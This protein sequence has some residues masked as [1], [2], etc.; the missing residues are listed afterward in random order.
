MIAILRRRGLGNGSTIGIKKYLEENHGRV[1]DIV[2]SD[3]IPDTEYAAVLRWGCTSDFRHAP[4]CI[5]TPEMI[6]AANDKIS[7]R[8]AMIEHEVTVPKTFFTKEEVNIFPVIGRPRFHAQGRKIV[9]SNNFDELN[10]DNTSEYWSEIVDKDREYRIYTFMGRILMVAEKVPT[11]VGRE[12]LAWNHFGG[13][14]VFNNVKWSEW[15]IEACKLGLKA[16]EAIGIDFSGV[17]VMTKGNKTYILEINSAH[18]LSSEYRKKTFAKAF[19]WLCKE[20]ETNN[21]KPEHFP[22]PEHIKTYKSII[23]PGLR[24]NG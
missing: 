10:D 20:I 9:V 12:R 4:I 19:D 23:L 18:S 6:H 2:R 15:P 17:D 16:A 21:E 5:N 7:C 22:F 8:K 1:V 24:N 3:R 11:E 14:A 13:G